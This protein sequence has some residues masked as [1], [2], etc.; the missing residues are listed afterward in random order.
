MSIS[1]TI[2]RHALRHLQTGARGRLSHSQAL[3]AGD[4]GS[5]ANL[6]LVPGA[7]VEVLRRGSGAW[8]LRVRQGSVIVGRGLVNLLEIEA[9]GAHAVP[10]KGGRPLTVPC[11]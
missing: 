8:V 6:G 4:W 10:A 7:E 9:V 3:A 11:G 5:L 2:T 1:S